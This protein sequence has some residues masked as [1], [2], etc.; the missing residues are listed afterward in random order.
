M[1]NTS[2]L[3]DAL[4]EAVKRVR[5]AIDKDADIELDKLL[6]KRDLT[7]IWKQCDDELRDRNSGVLPR[8]FF[9]SLL[10][11]L[12]RTEFPKEG[13]GAVMRRRKAIAKKLRKLQSSIDAEASVASL[14]VT[15]FYDDVRLN[16]HK[17][18]V[19]ELLKKLIV[20]TDRPLPA[21]RT[22]WG[23]KTIRR[24]IMEEK[25]SELFDEFLGDGKNHRDLIN[26]LTEA[27]LKENTNYSKV[28]LSKNHLG[29][30][31]R[32][33]KTRHRS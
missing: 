19:S 12:L 26:T 2:E 7:Q 5:R 17:L 27:V 4:Q 20:E 23:S 9:S 33:K 30:R 22:Q 28:T 10:L 14:D 25:L 1:S 13:S 24:Q 31:Q 21:D 18:T 3:P 29:A 16:H 32:A 11:I 15:R 6:G 8:A